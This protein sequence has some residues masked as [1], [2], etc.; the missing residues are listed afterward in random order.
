MLDLDPN[1]MKA[2]RNYVGKARRLWMSSVYVSLKK[3]M[4]LFKLINIFTFR[5]LWIHED[6]SYLKAGALVGQLPHAVQDQVHDFLADG[7][8]AA[9]VVV[10]RVLLTLQSEN[11][12]INF[13]KKFNTFN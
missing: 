4:K 10:C 1:K 9:R 3:P 12:V 5:I 13:C 6:P 11:T 7:V 2:V 8:V